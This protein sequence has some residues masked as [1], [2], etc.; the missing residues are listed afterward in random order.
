VRG[1][2]V[3]FDIFIRQERSGPK[4]GIE[5]GGGLPVSSDRLKNLTEAAF[6]ISG[7]TEGSVSL[8]VC[9]DPF[10]AGL[11][12]RYLGEE[13][14][15]DVLS[16]PLREGEFADVENPMLGDIVISTDTSARQAREAQNPIEAEFSGL[17]VHGLLHLLGY[18]HDSEAGEKLM[19]GVADTIL[20]EGRKRG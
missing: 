15:T 1:F 11:N 18:S 17:Y 20:S 5:K 2:D 3:A 7:K 4:R 12:E 8:V 6:L 9:D 10:I 14:P 19:R 16:F 13:G